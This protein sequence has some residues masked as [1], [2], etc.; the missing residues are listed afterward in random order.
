MY[1]IRISFTL[2]S[3]TELFLDTRASVTN[4]ITSLLSGVVRTKLSLG[5]I[6]EEGLKISCFVKTQE[7][8]ANIYGLMALNV[9]E[10]KAK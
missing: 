9:L 4:H 5:V 6:P 7:V 3:E 10:M 2:S 1:L 8:F